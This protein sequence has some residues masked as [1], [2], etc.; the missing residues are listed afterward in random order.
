MS[1]FKSPFEKLSYEAQREIA[2]SVQPGGAMYD[3]LEDI[4]DNINQLN[5]RESEVKRVS[6]FGGL[7]IKEALA[8]KFLGEKHESTTEGG[9]RLAREFCVT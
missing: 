4:A 5:A 1:A 3:L 7:T 9:G 6:L 2:D 8:W